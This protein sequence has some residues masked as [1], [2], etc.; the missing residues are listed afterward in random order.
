[1]TLPHNT[2]VK[3]AYDEAGRI[4]RIESPLWEQS[5][6]KYD[7]LG[8]VIHDALK[9][10]NYGYERDYAYD[11]LSQLTEERGFFSHTFKHDSLCNLVEEDG[12]AYDYNALNQPLNRD[13]DYDRNGNL[14]REGGRVYVYDS[15][16]RLIRVEEGGEVECYTYDELHRRLTA[17]AEKFIYLGADEVG[18]IE[19]GVLRSL[20]VL[21]KGVAAEI[22]ASMALEIEGEVFAPVHDRS[23]HI[24]AL[25]D[26]EGEVA[27]TLRYSAFGDYEASG[28]VASPW[29]F[30]SKRWDGKAK[31]FYFGRRYYNPRSHRWTTADPIKFDGGANLYAYVENNPLTLLDPYGLSPFGMNESPLAVYD[32]VFSFVSCVTQFV[33]KTVEAVGAHL[34]PIPLVRDVIEC[35]GYVMQGNDIKDY[36]M[37]YSRDHSCTGTF[38]GTNPKNS[39]KVLLTIN[40][41]CTSYA[42]Y[43]EQVAQF[44]ADHGGADVEY[45]YNGTNGVICDL[46]ECSMQKIGIPT[47]P[48]RMLH[49]K[50]KSIIDERGGVESDVQ[51]LMRAHSQGGLIAGNMVN[52]LSHDYTTKIHLRTMGSASVVSNRGFGSVINYV[53]AADYVPLTDPIGYLSAMFLKDRTM[54]ISEPSRF[55]IMEHCLVDESY[56]EA[57]DRINKEFNKFLQG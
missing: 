42:E 40:G 33:G 34:V 21:G 14:I 51:I 17:G 56:Q 18:S 20:R 49:E 47:R 7:S 52:Y 31:L 16:D 35:A 41:I 37:S 57:S 54:L 22:G 23:G 32:Y 30:S 27:Q 53:A 44:S 11:G 9:E 29:L 50:V 13:E 24:T 36:K 10:G 2:P 1:M 4:D 26:K 3:I 46:L 6:V 15:L 8:N 25:Y 12:A 43:M 39:N 45:V 48:E 19:E 55:H 28:R 38:Q 5:E